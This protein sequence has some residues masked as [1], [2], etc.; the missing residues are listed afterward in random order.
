MD[1]KKCECWDEVHPGWAYSSGVC[2]GTKERDACDCGGDERKCDFYPERRKTNELKPCPFC[3]GKAVMHRSR[4]TNN[5]FVV[6][7]SNKDEKCKA[8]PCTNLFDT[9]EE[10]AEVWNRRAEP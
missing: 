3:G 1:T 8:E 5:R 2:N 10:A 9:Q 4:H 6:Y 7:C